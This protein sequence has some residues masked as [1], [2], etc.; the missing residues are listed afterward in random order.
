MNATPNTTMTLTDISTTVAT[1]DTA[2]AGGSC[3][4]CAP[5]QATPNQPSRETA[6]SADYSV[7]GLTCG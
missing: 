1:G 7:S 3:G 4:C 5:Q 6:V 2:S